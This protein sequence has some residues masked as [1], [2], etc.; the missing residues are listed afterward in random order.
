[1]MH[2]PAAMHLHGGFGNSDIVG[3]LFAKAPARYL[4]HDFALPRAQRGET[5]PEIRQSFLTFAS[6]TSARKAELN[7]IKEVL[8]AEWLGQELNG[9]PFH[10]LHR[11][12]DVTMPCDEDDW[13]FP[14]CQSQF[15][16]Q[17]QA[18]LP[19]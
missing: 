6:C 2:R 14:F 4:N 16:L 18:A 5:L 19:R 3:Y 12:W 17:I 7:G 13:E 15:P 11:H 8:I 9:A 1:L 10:R